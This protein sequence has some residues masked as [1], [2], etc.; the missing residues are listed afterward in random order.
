V[1]APACCTVATIVNVA[2]DVDPAA[3]SVPMFHKPVADE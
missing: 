2:V 1:S 3:V